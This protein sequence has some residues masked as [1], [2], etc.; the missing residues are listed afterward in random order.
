MA[1]VPTYTE[2]YEKL[3]ET[4]KALA[5][6]D[7]PQ[8]MRMV[9]IITRETDLQGRENVARLR[10]IFGPQFRHFFHIL[11]PLEPGVVVGKSSAMAYGGRWLYKE[12]TSL[13]FDPRKVVV[14]DLDS[15]YRVHRQY[16]GYLTHQFITNRDR[17]PAPLPARPD[18]PQQPLAVPAA[19]PPHRGRVDSRPDVAPPDARTAGQ[20][21][22]VR[23]FASR[24][25]T[26]WTTGRR[27]PSRRTA[28]STGRASSGTAASSA[29]SP[30]SFPCTATPSGPG[31]TRAASMQQYTQIRRWAWGVT[32]IPFFIGNALTHN[33][34]PLRERI[35]RLFDLWVE[36]INW[37][38]APF[39]I[40][41]GAT[42]PV[43]L[44]QTFAQ[45]LFRP[46]AA[47]L[48]VVAAHRGPRRA[49]RPDLHRGSAGAAAAA[50][51][52]DRDAHRLVGAV[53]LPCRSWA[54]SSRTCPPSTPRRGCSPAAT[55]STGSPRRPDVRRAVRPA[56]R[57][58]GRPGRRRGRALSGRSG[59]IRATR[60]LAA[61]KGQP[62]CRLDHSVR[63]RGSVEICDAAPLTRAGA[64]ALNATEPRTMFRP[65]S[66][67]PDLVAA[68]HEILALW[69]ERKTF[70]RLRAQNAG[71]ERWSFLDGPITANNPMGVHHAWGRA[72]KDLFQRFHAMLGQDQR[73]QNGFDCQGLWVEVNVERDLGF[74][75]KR[76]IE[77]YGIAEFVSLCKQR[78][79]TY[80]ARQTEQSI[81]LGMWM[82]WN[83]PNELRRLRDLLAENPAQ[84]VTTHEH[85]RQTR[86]GHGRDDRRAA[87]HARDGRQ[88][89]HV[90]QREQLP[91][92]VASWPSATGAAGST[93]ATTR[94]PGAPAAAPA[95]ASTR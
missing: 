75:S 45:T 32:D 36:H 5:D 64:I 47:G 40:V 62:S 25:S 76:D 91:D 39:V 90:L 18:V 43:A 72:Y 56:R 2:P 70:A 16:F 1:L 60:P 61:G 94:C 89:L 73:Y 6:S 33:E 83:D 66:S 80:A 19:G 27:T 31:R 46:A 53:G 92:L 48:C 7:Y 3:Y 21:Q 22:L 13:G 85:R 79:L 88:L 81:R 49:H 69:R 30:C 20:L 86:D 12:L 35:A 95:S 34:I 9:A 55:W 10:E 23:G 59:R 37:A 58:R 67:K 74:T 38:I 50:G 51:V 93:R 63:A 41:L 42:L 78:V 24:P 17:Y 52:G 68:E 65:V 14:T 71:N 26:R 54:P 84:T 77:D 28:A 8:D 57:L 11:D 87:R 44:N 4:V 15:D 29:R 82:D